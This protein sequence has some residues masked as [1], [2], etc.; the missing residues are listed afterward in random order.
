M[1]VRGIRSRRLGISTSLRVLLAS[2]VRGGNDS[3]T[4]MTNPL[5]FTPLEIVLGVSTLS[6][7]AIAVFL[8]AGAARSR[9]EWLP[10]GITAVLAVA[11]PVVGP[12]AA[13]F[14]CWN[15][16]RVSRTAPQPKEPAR[17][18]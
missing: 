12:A 2:R 5:A 8:L 9:F 3:E 16:S 14:I 6:G 7:I 10:A 17:S 11:V 1:T 18:T 15:L 4:V 13:L